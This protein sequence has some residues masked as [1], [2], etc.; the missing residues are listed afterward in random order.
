MNLYEKIWIYQKAICVCFQ[1]LHK[2]GANMWQRNKDGLTALDFVRSQCKQ[3]RSARWFKLATVLKDCMREPLSL[4]MMSRNALRKH[5]GKMYYTKVRSLRVHDVPVT[6]MT[7]IDFLLYKDLKTH[8]DKE[9]SS[10]YK[11]DKLD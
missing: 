4:Q 5:I 8:F 1:V 6:D 3:N 10:C 7:I 9:I 2:Y 11:K